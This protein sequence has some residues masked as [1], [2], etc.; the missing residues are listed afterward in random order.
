MADINTHELAW[1]AGFFDG[2]GHIRCDTRVNGVKILQFKIS[3]NDPAVLV[4]F[5]RA[6]FNLGSIYRPYRN[7]TKS[8]NQYYVYQIHNFESV[9]AVCAAMW[10]YLSPV[11]R[12]QV[13]SA[14]VDWNSIPHLGNNV[15][16]RRP[17]KV[18]SAI[19]DQRQK[20]SHYEFSMRTV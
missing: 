17:I 5:K 14:L 10:K 6:V 13:V 1:A 8:Y 20:A 4:R 2:E 16:P 19:L 18:T 11:K 9:Q 12:E 7:G 15:G 3:Q